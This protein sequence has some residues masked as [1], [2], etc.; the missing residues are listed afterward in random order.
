MGSHSW[1]LEANG[2]IA[3]VGVNSF[4]WL[5]LWVGTKYSL[6]ILCPSEWKRIHP[7][8]TTSRHGVCVPCIGMNN[9]S[10]INPC[11]FCSCCFRRR[12]EQH[13]LHIDCTSLVESLNVIWSSLVMSLL[14]PWAHS[15]TP[16]VTSTAIKNMNVVIVDST[17]VLWNSFVFWC[18]LPAVFCFL[19]YKLCIPNQSCFCLSDLT[20]LRRFPVF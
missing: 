12:T 3:V 10:M 13:I 1:Y 5:L 6:N 17:Y 8:L 20:L 15:I 14:F 4:R 19:L 9:A 11:W 18:T 7:F 2:I 16:M